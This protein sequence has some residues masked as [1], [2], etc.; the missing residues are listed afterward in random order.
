MVDSTP[1]ADDDQPPTLSRLDDDDPLFASIVPDLPDS[2]E[3]DALLNHP[4]LT[5]ARARATWGPQDQRY[6]VRTFCD[7]CGYWGRVRCSKCG[8]RVCALDCLEVHRED[9][10]TR[11]GL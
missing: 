4:Q 9:C 11:Y 8:T 10:I 7:V 6:P 5:Y 3:L 2:G 1:A